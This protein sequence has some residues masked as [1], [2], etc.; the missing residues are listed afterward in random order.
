MYNIYEEDK[1]MSKKVR[2]T[3]TLNKDIDEQL[4]K[5]AGEKG[6]SRSAVVERAINDNIDKLKTIKKIEED[7]SQPTAF[8]LDKGVIQKLREFSR[9]T[10]IKQ[11]RVIEL[12]LLEVFNRSI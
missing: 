12:V 1:N 9:Q 8:T 5:Y 4:N 2:M 10:G 3:T 7:K 6:L 11:A